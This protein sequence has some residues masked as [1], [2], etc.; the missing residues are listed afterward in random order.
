[1]SLTSALSSAISGLNASSRAV[2]VVSSNLANALTEGHAPRSLELSARRDG[3]GVQVTGVTRQA[4]PQLVQDRRLATSELAAQQTRAGA[5]AQ[6]ERTVGTP[7]EPGSLSGLLVTFEADLLAAAN[8]PEADDRLQAAVASAVALADRFGAVSDTLQTM[9]GQA[10]TDIERAVGTINAQLSEVGRLNG[11]IVAARAGGNG[12][13]ALEDN[14]QVAI[15]R[16][17]D[18]LP[19]RQVARDNGAVALFTT[20]GAT[21]LDGVPAQFAFSAVNVIA[22]H[23]TAGNGL[24]SG[25]SINGTDVDATKP[26]GPVGGGQ[27]AALFTVRDEI[28]VTAQEN[29]DAL[30]RNLIERFQQPGLDAT[31]AP[32]DPGLFTDAG[33]GFD[34][35][36]ESGVSG[37]IAVNAAVDPAAGG[38]LTRLRDGLGATAPGPAGNGALLQQL[39]DTLISRD[40]LAS[41]ALGATARSTTGHFAGLAS[42][43]AQSRIAQDQSV[44]FAAARQGELVALELER[45]V[46]SDAELQRML[47]I[48]QAFSANARMIQTLDDMMQTLLRI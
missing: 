28:A 6:I 31:R 14:R 37:R 9:R 1:M 21:L 26:T 40:A 19:L 17:A 30:A 39:A 48:E 10:E 20:G 11:L 33:A 13:A 15:D 4:D 47:V 3:G 46:D 42:E 36:D 45:G 7:G 5:F 27:L 12:T 25:L 16:L 18:F 22:P 32:G 44:S 38:M 43:I 34:A 29:L 8:R 24:L 23:M 2:D 35:A 41:G